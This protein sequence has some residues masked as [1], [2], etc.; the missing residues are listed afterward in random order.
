MLR[1]FI[2]ILFCF[3]FLLLSSSGVLIFAQETPTFRVHPDFT[4]YQFTEDDGLVSSIVRDVIS[5]RE[6]YLWFGT[7]EGI[8]RFDGKQTSNY[9]AISNPGLG[10]NIIVQ[11]AEGPGNSVW[12]VSLPN[13]LSVF[14]NGQFKT[15]ISPNELALNRE[16]V[17]VSGDSVWIM[18]RQGVALY[19]DG[20]LTPY[21]QDV[22]S[23]QVTSIQKDDAGW[24][25]VATLD[26]GLYRIASGTVVGEKTGSAF[27][28]N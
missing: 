26:D 18:T 5:T 22:I 3:F 19:E 2:R 6:G 13:K 8:A 7:D 11:L 27:Y 17:Y 21:R 28:N 24:L 10:S 1:S 23:T 25:W 16:A 12:V 20:R 15:V 4:A 14:E 9:T